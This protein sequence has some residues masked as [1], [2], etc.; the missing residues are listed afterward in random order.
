[1]QK[2]KIIYTTYIELSWL[3][4]RLPEHGKRQLR[5]QQRS[6]WRGWGRVTMRTT[7]HN[8]NNNN[9]LCQ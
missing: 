9:K 1:M 3:F 5:R 8:N 4:I 2:R 7:T 6:Q